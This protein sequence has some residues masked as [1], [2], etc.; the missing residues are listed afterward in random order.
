MLPF[1]SHFEITMDSYEEIVSFHDLSY[2]KVL[3]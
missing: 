1:P 2:I 3:I